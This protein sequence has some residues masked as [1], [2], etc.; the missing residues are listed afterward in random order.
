VWLISFASKTRTESPNLKVGTP[1]FTLISPIAFDAALLG[2][3]RLLV[4]FTFSWILLSFLVLECF[5]YCM[6]LME[7]AQ[8][9]S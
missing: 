3:D 7:C 2:H 1:G 9:L 5:C 6:G 4:I 8:S